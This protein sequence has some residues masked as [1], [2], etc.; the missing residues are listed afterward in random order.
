MKLTD[1]DEQYTVGVLGDP[2]T[3]KTHLIGTL[4]KLMP[5][6]V[7]TADADGLSTL[8]SMNVGA[9]VIL[10]SDWLDIWARLDEITRLAK[11]FKAIALDDFGSLQDAAVTKVERVPRSDR[12]ARMPPAD[13]VTYIRQQILEGNRK[14]QLQQY[15]EITAASDA[16][17]YEFMRLPYRLKVIT[18]LSQVREHPRTGKDHIYP[19]TTGAIRDELLARFSLIVNSFIAEYRGQVHYCLTCKPHPRI[20]T[21]T[22]YGVG[23]TWV[24]PDF[25]ALL[26]HMQRK[27][28]AESATEKAIGTG[29]ST[30]D[31]K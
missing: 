2:K 8:K 22:R 20:P 1:I 28:E 26:T 24:D 23:R 5:T 11:D 27:E 9:E 29:L 31:S 18:M 13:R 3:G 7:V 10:V 25:T 21:N 19:N 6:V 15:G 14:L 16:F 12:E 30:S 17:L 4:C